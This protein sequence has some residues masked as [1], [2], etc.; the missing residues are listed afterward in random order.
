LRLRKRPLDLAEV[1][2]AWP[3]L[4]DEVRAQILALVRRG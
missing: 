1:I 4:P 3:T 2:D